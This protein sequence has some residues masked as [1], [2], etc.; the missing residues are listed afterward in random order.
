MAAAEEQQVIHKWSFNCKFDEDTK[1]IVL[2]VEDSVTE[3]KWS[4]R[5]KCEDVGVT[6][7]EYTEKFSNVLDDESTGL[8]CAYPDDDKDPLRIVFTSAGGQQLW[9]FYLDLDQ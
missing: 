5:L 2:T 6:E 9:E 1:R 8:G 3:K 4:K 7:D